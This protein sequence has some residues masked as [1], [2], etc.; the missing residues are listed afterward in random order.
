MAPLANLTGCD[1]AREVSGFVNAQLDSKK[2]TVGSSCSAAGTKVNS[3]REE[4]VFASAG[5]TF[6]VKAKTDVAATLQLYGLELDCA[7]MDAV[8][9]EFWAH[10]PLADFV[11]AGGV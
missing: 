10:N 3:G 11:K 6:T 7:G 1:I 8:M 5:G 2:L 4:T 9:A